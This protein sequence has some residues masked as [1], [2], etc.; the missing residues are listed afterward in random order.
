MDDVR[1]AL[2]FGRD[3]QLTI[4]VRSGGHGFPGLSTCDDGLLIDLRPMTGVRVDPDARTV[5]VQAGVLLGELDAA[6]QEHGLAVPAG[7][8]SHTGWPA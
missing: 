8:V 4:A 3:Q 5:G 2:G 7:I 6:T 1:A